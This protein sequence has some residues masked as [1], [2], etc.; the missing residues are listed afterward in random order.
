MPT[1]DARLRFA[2][3]Q[4]GFVTPLAR[5]FTVSF[6]D[7]RVDGV[8]MSPQ[9]EPLLLDD[10]LRVVLDLQMQWIKGGWTPIRSKDD[11]PFADTAEW[12]ASLQKCKSN[13]TFWQASGKYQA[14]LNL[15]CFKDDKHPNEVRYLITLEVSKPYAEP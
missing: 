5:F 1:S 8:R 7:G 13:A 4:Y 15:N 10:A 12:R 14:Q 9:I 3:P 2:D 6:A 11:P